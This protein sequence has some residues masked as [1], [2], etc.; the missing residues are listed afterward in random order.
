MA[1]AVRMEPIELHE[2]V[3]GGLERAVAFAPRKLR[4]VTE[5]TPVVKP[6]PYAY[7]FVT[8]RSFYENFTKAQTFNE[9]IE[10][11]P[12]RTR[13]NALFDP[14]DCQAVLAISRAEH[15]EQVSKAMALPYLQRR[16]A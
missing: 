2:P 6:S 13:T 15:E 7:L 3:N 8:A 14:V 16:E 10:S 4:L 9:L 1:T 5:T 12:S 11:A